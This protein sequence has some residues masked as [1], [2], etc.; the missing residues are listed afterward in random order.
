MNNNDARLLYKI[1]F[2]NNNH[3]IQAYSSE[4]I[5]RRESNRVQLFQRAKS[6]SGSKKIILSF[7]SQRAQTL[8]IIIQ[9]CN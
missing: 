2:H 9:I 6:R 4:E 7:N 3:P 8:I 1:S 5:Q